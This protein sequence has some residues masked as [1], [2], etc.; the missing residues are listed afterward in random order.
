MKKHKITPQRQVILDKLAAG[1]KIMAS[2]EGGVVHYGYLNGSPLNER[3]VERM[4]KNGM[5]KG[6]E[7]GLEPGQSQT[8]VF[9]DWACRLS[10]KK[11]CADWNPA[12]RF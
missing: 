4:I 8:Y 10:L 1:E 5:L 9:P 7:D 6:C 3:V 12:M 2:H 11:C